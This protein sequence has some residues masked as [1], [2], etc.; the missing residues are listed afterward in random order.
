MRVAHV[1]IAFIQVH[2]LFYILIG[3]IGPTF[4]LRELVKLVN[5]VT[6]SKV[7]EFASAS[8]HPDAC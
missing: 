1:H 5:G 8:V 3:I 7:N 4:A 2:N 6:T